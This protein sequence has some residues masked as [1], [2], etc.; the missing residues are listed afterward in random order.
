MFYCYDNVNER[1]EKFDPRFIYV[2]FFLL[3]IMLM[4]VSAKKPK[5]VVKNKYITE[6]MSVII[7]GAEFSKGK[8]YDYIKMCGI[9]FPDIVYAQAV[10]ETGNFTSDRF[11][12]HNNAFGMKVARSRPTTASGEH[13]DHAQYDT[14]MLSVQDYAL[15]QSAYLRDLRT[16]R[17]YLSYLSQHYAEDTAYIEKLKKIIDKL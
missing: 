9:R 4:M 12:E 13:T 16:E 2:L 8:F 5:L 11:L 17:D 3:I 14:W 15:Y 10:L 1:Y 7:K 6:E